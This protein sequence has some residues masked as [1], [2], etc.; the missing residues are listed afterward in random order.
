MDVVNRMAWHMDIY[1]TAVVYTYK[2]EEDVFIKFYKAEC[3]CRGSFY[4]SAPPHD[5][6]YYDG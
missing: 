1:Y 6:L 5:S 3:R 4:V 2:I